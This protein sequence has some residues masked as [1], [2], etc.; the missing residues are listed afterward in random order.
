MKTLLLKTLLKKST[1]NNDGSVNLLFQ[2]MEEIDSKDFLL[3][4]QYWKQNGWLAFKM[5]E[6][7]GTEMPKGNATSEGDVSPS[8]ALRQSLYAKHMSLGGTKETFLPYYNKAIYGF[9]K[10]VDDS[11]ND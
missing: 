11:F 9:K 8:Q 10:A 3:M 7:D 1:R 5:N 4:D 6:F 2:T